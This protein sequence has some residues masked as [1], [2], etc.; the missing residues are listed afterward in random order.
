MKLNPLRQ[1]VCDE[2]Q[3]IIEKVE[4][5]WMEWFDGNEN[6]LHGYRIVHTPEASPR[7]ENGGDCHYPN[8]SNVS[9]LQLKVFTGSDGLA[10]LLSFFERKLAVPNE[11]AEI[12]RRLH[13]P[14]YEEARQYLEK[15]YIDSV[16]VNKVYGQEDLKK[17]IK[18]Y[19]NNDK[20]DH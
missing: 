7:F 19:A 10:L 3:A 8:G 15:A 13:V 14:H 17:V 16:I 12:I 2:C 4:D 18:T 9:G 6:P 11:F 5:G 20:G 1:F